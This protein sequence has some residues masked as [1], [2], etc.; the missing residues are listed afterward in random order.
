MGTMMAQAPGVV[1]GTA[2]RP[3]NDDE[4]EL[5]IEPAGYRILVEIIPPQ[6]S[7]KRWLNS[8]LVAPDEVRDREW[9][10]QVWAVVLRLGPDAYADKAKFPTGPW[11]KTGDHVL[12]RPY[13]GTRFLVHGR[14]YALVNDD[15]VQAVVG[16]VSEVE[17]A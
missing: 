3:V 8:N 1:T 10:A 15:T 17:R 7:L 4:L 6:E 16:D 13:S 9:A 2:T 11:C 14:L 5:T 12:M